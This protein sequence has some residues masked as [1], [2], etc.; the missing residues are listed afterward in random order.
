MYECGSKIEIKREREKGIWG[1]TNHTDA[2]NENKVIQQ[3]FR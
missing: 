1:R 2:G 3:K